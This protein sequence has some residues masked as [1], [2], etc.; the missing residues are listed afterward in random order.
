ML[1]AGVGTACG[2]GSRESVNQSNQGELTAP[3]SE[4]TIEAGVRAIIQPGGSV[5]DDE[6]VAAADAAGITMVFTRRPHF[7][8]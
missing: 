4:S 2:K 8:H 1:G 5:R 7:R 3:G 6:V